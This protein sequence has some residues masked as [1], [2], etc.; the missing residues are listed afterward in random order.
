MKKERVLGVTVV[1]L[2]AWSF[3]VPRAMAENGW[4]MLFTGS[5]TRTDQFKGPATVSD[6][7]IFRTSQVAY[8]T[9]TA[10]PGPVSRLVDGEW[11]RIGA[12]HKL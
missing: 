8:W 9:V 6:C 4:S 10:D 5:R 12:F 2:L 1:V 7:W 11:H 3:S